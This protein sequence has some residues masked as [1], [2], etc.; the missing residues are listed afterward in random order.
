MELEHEDQLCDRYR[1]LLIALLKN[2]EQ[3]TELLSTKIQD[4]V[5]SMNELESADS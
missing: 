4:A 1:G 2:T 3:Q 5:N